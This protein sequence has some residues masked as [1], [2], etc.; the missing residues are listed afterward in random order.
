VVQIRALIAAGV[1]VGEIAV[2]VRINA[3]TERFEQALTAAQVPYV[4][5]GVERFYDR[6]VVRR[7]LVLFRGAARGAAAGSAPAPLPAA[8]RDVLTG[9]GFTAGPPAGGP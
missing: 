2:L 8:V 9:I 3:D 7:A 5:R 6:P 4:V 1:P